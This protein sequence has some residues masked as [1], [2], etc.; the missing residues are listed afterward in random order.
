MIEDVN[1]LRGHQEVHKVKPGNMR[2]GSYKIMQEEKRRKRQNA[3]DMRHSE[4]HVLKYKVCMKNKERTL[5][6]N[7]QRRGSHRRGILAGV[8]Y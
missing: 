6:R 2:M 7:Q 4:R 5:S 1:Q 8:L 3:D